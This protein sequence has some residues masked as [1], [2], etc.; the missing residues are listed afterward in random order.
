[1]KTK[2]NLIMIRMDKIFLKL[3]NILHIQMI[4]KEYLL[5]KKNQMEMLKQ[6]KFIQNMFQLEV[7]KVK[8]L[9]SL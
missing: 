6:E 3:M 5:E 2:L 9:M 7:I 1:M 4:P 8:P